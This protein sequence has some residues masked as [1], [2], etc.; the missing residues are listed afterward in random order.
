MAHIKDDRVLETSTTTGTGNIELDGAEDTYFTFASAMADG[1][2]A[3]V[4][5]EHETLD[6]VE[7]SLVTMTSGDLARTEV[8]KSSNAGALV[9]FSAGTKRVYMSLVARRHAVSSALKVYMAERFC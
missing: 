1:D 4:V 9:N 6:E 3:F 5:I 7:I 8:V 2:T